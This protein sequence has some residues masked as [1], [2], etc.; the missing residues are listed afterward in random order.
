MNFR[1]F[2]NSSGLTLIEVLASLS[3][4]AVLIVLSSTLIIQLVNSEEKT[5]ST[6]SLQQNTNVLINVIRTQYYQG[7]STICLNGEARI[8]NQD[9]STFVN[10]STSLSY[11]D[12]CINGVDTD[13]PLTVHLVTKNKNAQSLTIETTLTNNDDYILNLE[14]NPDDFV[15]GDM[16]EACTFEGNTK[17]NETTLK[18]KQN[19][20]CYDVYTVHGSAAFMGDL[21]IHNKVRITVDGNFYVF[22][23]L[24]F[25]GA[26]GMICVKKD[27]KTP[28]TVG[29]FD[30]KRNA[31]SC[32]EPEG[33]DIYI[34]GKK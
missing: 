27:V 9:E 21:T 15:L 23:N 7:N 25:K 2:K 26:K 1:Q 20:D 33:Y 14:E 13:S 30:I 31:E 29:D 10:G 24:D 22:G 12:G 19:Q 32:F 6:I 28:E 34:L 18:N 4:L 17:F 3:L 16:E 8:I 5:N 11:N